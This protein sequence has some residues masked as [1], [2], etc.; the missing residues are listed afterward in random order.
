MAERIALRT[1]DVQRDPDTALRAVLSR[2]IRQ[3]PYSR[4]QIADRLSRLL[5]RKLAVHAVNSWT[6][7]TKRRIGLRAAWLPAFC[8]AV[9]NDLPQVALLSP[10]ARARLEIK[11]DLK[12]LRSAITA[13]LSVERKRARARNKKTG[14]SSPGEKGKQKR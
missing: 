4:E 5:G 14:R 6:A 9:G 2:A 11:N 13:L 12:S 8:V 10:K 1:A 7:K 3:S